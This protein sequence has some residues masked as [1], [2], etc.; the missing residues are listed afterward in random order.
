ME[1]DHSSPEFE[2]GVYMITYAP[3][4]SEKT[5]TGYYYFFHEHGLFH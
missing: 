5:L 1:A 3:K 2:E 4:F